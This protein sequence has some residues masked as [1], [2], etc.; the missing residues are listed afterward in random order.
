MYKNTLTQH[1][2]IGELAKEV[3]ISTAT[4]RYYEAE[5][6][7]EKPIRISGQRRY[8]EEA[9]VTLRRLVNARQLGFSI[10]ELRML[11][12]EYASPNPSDNWQALAT[13]KLP[14]L[15]A[16]IAQAQKLKCVLMLG[17]ACMCDTI[18]ACFDTA[19]MV[20]DDCDCGECCA[21]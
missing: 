17:L 10:G 15:D 21:V 18:M 14:E 13:Q 7:L 9:L 2:T 12:G 11:F 16:L 19:E 4:I 6:L 5:G 1:Y 3:G 20:C 8:T